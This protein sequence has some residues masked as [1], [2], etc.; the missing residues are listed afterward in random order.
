[1]MYGTPLR[2]SNFEKAQ[3]EAKTLLHKLNR[4]DAA[5]AQFDVTDVFPARLRDAQYLVARRYGFR[6]WNALKAFLTSQRTFP[7]KSV[8]G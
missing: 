4:K 1:M 3:Q 6:S 2:I 5:P 8:P 7:H